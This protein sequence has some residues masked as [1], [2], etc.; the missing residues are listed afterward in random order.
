MQIFQGYAEKKSLKSILQEKLTAYRI[1]G[2]NSITD[3][4]TK[5]LS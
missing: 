1:G 4:A 2:T 3:L 5:R